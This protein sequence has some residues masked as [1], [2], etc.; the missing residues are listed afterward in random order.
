V[1]TAERFGDSGWNAGA[2]LRMKLL[3]AMLFIEGRYHSVS[4][5][6]AKMT[7]MPITVGLSF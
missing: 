7:I 6:G 5:V 2:G 4:T 1:P 3:A